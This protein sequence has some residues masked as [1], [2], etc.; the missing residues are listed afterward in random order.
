MTEILYYRSQYNY[1]KV[2]PIEISLHERDILE[3]RKPFQ[4]TLE[5][6]E[7]SPEGWLLGTNQRTGETGYF[8][9]TYVEFMRSCNV[10]PPPTHVVPKRPVPQP[11]KNLKVDAI[12]NDG[13]DS[14]YV[15]S[16]GKLLPNVLCIL[17][18]FVLF[19][20]PISSWKLPLYRTRSGRT[21]SGMLHPT[22]TMMI[23][24]D[25][26]IHVFQKKVFIVE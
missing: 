20:K 19:K 1:T 24:F 15:C 5:G 23:P 4:F 11:T 10:N 17:F 16:P 18:R 13:N 25:A 21:R 8:P 2:E 14:G 7:S 12:E 26:V 3:V 22:E 9:G 6:T